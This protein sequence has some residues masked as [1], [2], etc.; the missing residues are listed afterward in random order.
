MTQNIVVSF[1]LQFISGHTSII[2]NLIYLPSFPGD[3]NKEFNQVK[4]SLRAK[5][6]RCQ[7]P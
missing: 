5:K 2:N 7:Q 1:S 6:A 4:E 3:K